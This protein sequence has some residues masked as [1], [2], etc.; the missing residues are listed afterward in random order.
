MPINFFQT[1]NAVL[2]QG[3]SNICNVYRISE[4]DAVERARHYLADNTM[5]YYSDNT[6]LQYNDPLC[7]IAY[8]YAYVGAHANLTDNAFYKFPDLRQFVINQIHSSG[9]LHVCSFGGG[10]GSELLGFVK[11]IQRVR[12]EDD[13][14][15][16]HF[17]LIDQIPEWDETWQAL[18]NGLQ[19]TF[20]STYGPSR[21]HWPIVVHRSFLP[22]DL[23]QVRDFQSFPSRFNE[24]QLYV[25]NHTISELLVRRNEFKEVFNYVVARASTGAYF[26]F[27]DRNQNEVVDFA[28]ELAT[29]DEL[30]FQGIEFEQTNMDLDEQKQD[31]GNWYILMERSPKITWNAFYALAHKV[32]TF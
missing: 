6:R 2:T 3:I 29:H 30:E 12:D 32:I 14:I 8:L 24:V 4:T 17:T 1:L 23:T 22:L 25:L 10:P 27:I 13:T 15:D 20:K 5:Q 9:E 7:R 16:I 21:R 18:V 31:L 11:F 28:R 19:E 26:L